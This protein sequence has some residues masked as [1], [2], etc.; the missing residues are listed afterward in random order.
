MFYQG[1][2]VDPCHPGVVYHTTLNL[3]RKFQF[4]RN[5]NVTR[6]FMTIVGK[7]FQWLEFPIKI[8]SMA[9]KRKRYSPTTFGLTHSGDS[10]RMSKPKSEKLPK[11][12]IVLSGKLP[13]CS[14][15]LLN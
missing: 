10:A 11:F 12:Y 2:L 8:K 9:G 14:K 15:F 7:H 3:Y 13:K 4:I 5:F 1:W 6:Y